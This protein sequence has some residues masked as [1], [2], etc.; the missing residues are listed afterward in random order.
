MQKSP[1]LEKS[2]AHSFQLYKEKNILQMLFQL[3]EYLN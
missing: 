2:Q 1:P 3:S